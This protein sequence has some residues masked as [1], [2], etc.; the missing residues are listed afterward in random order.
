MSE[1]EMQEELE[2]TT[3]E[4]A[5]GTILGEYKGKIVCMPKDTRLNRHIAIFGASGTM[6]SRAV[7]RNALFQAMK[8][9]ESVIITDS[10]AELYADT[11]EMYRNNGYEVKV[12]NLVTP[13]HSD[14]WNCM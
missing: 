8:R 6:K 4:K 10:K 9:G 13:E 7:I 11:A 14:S 12:F 3:P 5:E 1:K 2:V